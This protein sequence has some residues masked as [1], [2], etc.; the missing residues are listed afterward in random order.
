MLTR[1][2]R[3]E[4]R[5][6]REALEDREED[7]DARAVVYVRAGAQAEGVSRRAFREAVARYAGGFAALGV[8]P[9][10][11]VVIAHAEGLD[12]LFAFWGLLRIGAIP[13]M[14]PTLTE[15]LDPVAYRANMGVLV[16]HSGARMVVTTG[17]FAP[18]LSEVVGC[19]TNGFGR[20]R[21]MAG[22]EVTP[23]EPAPDAIAF[24][25]HSSGTTGLQKGVALSHR[26]VLNQVASYSDALQ[27]GPGDV[28][29]SWLPLYHDMGL[30]AG[31]LLPVLQGLPLVLMSPFDWVKRPALLLRAIN[32]HG[33]TLC[34]LP[35]FAYNHCARR[36]LDREVRGLT[37]A[38][39]RAF[40]NCS[41]P[42]LDSSQN[43]FLDRFAPLGVRPDQ[44]AASYAMAENVFAVTQTPIARPPRLDVVDREALAREGRAEPAEG[45]A[46]TAAVLVSCG[47]PIPDVEVR[48][49]DG[50]PDRRVGE[51]Q[52]RSHCMLSGYY[53]RPDLDAQLFDDGWYRTGD[54][55]YMARGELYVVGRKKDLIISGGRNLHPHDIE[56][57]VTSV[58]GVH[59]GRSVVFGVPDESEGTE[60]VA[61]VAEVDTE[62]D[63]ARLAVAGAIRQALAG[64]MGI[65]ASYV[66]IVGPRW[67]VKTSSGKIARS[68][69]REKWLAERQ[70]GEP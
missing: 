43:A 6:L 48:I 33:G 62:D 4:A 70:R 57:I 2:G 63:A 11:V 27:L 65:V 36:V 60:L 40:I 53:R 3:A 31:F 19:P 8:R 16:E 9:S 51:I 42:V 10:D 56:A 64:Q 54:L 21:S 68:A 67:L 5:N 37:L 66:R 35:N 17:E 41:E 1:A 15:K 49:S 30:I 20:I 46:A 25:Q 52:V 59:P 45:G 32:D 7:A 38:G 13:S 69:N 24:L 61:V 26:A 12:A 28:I 34:W 58:P 39:M 44:L 18:V 55:G 14:F 22:P 29:V 23:F 47:P 50:L